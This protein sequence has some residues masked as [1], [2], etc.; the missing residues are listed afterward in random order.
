VTPVV[1]IPAAGGILVALIGMWGV[2]RTAKVARLS[3]DRMA[4]I[5]GWKEWRED[6]KRLREENAQ[7]NAQIKQIREDC[8]GREQRLADELELVE[9]RLDATVAWVRM[10]LPVMRQRGVTFPPPPRGITDTDPGLPLA[11]RKQL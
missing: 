9:A 11:R 5:E 1:W 3:N 2:I 7:L 8:T 10:I 4:A 6:A